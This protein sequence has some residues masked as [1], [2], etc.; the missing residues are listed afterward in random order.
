[1]KKLEEIVRAAS[2]SSIK[3]SVTGKVFYEAI[4]NINFIQH[5]IKHIFT[6]KP[7]FSKYNEV[8]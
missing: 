2:M 5:E 3:G 1:M 6:I 7:T 4:E 8:D